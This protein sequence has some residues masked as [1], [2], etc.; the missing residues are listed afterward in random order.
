M[1]HGP[2][3]CLRLEPP[4]LCAPLCAVLMIW[5]TPLQHRSGYEAALDAW[6][7]QLWGVLGAAAPLPGGLPRVSASHK[8]GRGRGVRDKCT[9]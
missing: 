4:A 2:L 1:L 7:T 6:L 8:A 3:V 9:A 5:C